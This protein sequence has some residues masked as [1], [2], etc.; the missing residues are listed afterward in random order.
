MIQLSEDHY[1]LLLEPLKQVDFNTLFIRSVIAGHTGGKVF[2]DSMRNPTSFYAVHS[3]GMSLLFGNANNDRF[4]SDL[5]NYFNQKNETRNRDEWLQAHPRAW[6]ALLESILNAGRATRYNRLNFRFDKDEFE[7]S[8]SLLSFENYTVVPT[9]ASMFSSIKGSVTPRVFWRDEQQFSG[10]ASFTA[11]VDGEPAS[12]AFTSYRHDE[13][14]EIGIETEEKYRGRGLARA[15]CVKLINYCIENNLKPMWSCCLENAAS[16]N[17]AK[18]LGFQETVCMPY[19][20]I[21]A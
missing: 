5:Y 18:K 10:K 21:P 4:N 16:T 19:Y 11:M 7:K 6:D 3:Y 20:H 8:N 9:T 1:E 12:T 15:V 14:L 2:V 13:M 17:L